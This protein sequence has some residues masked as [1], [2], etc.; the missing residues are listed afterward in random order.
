MH[1]GQSVCARGNSA[2]FRKNDAFD[3]LNKWIDE[4]AQPTI[5]PWP[6]TSGV[7]TSFMCVADA[8]GWSQPE[9][10]PRNFGTFDHWDDDGQL[11]PSDAERP[12][13]CRFAIQLFGHR[14][15]G[16]FLRT[17]RNFGV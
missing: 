13:D 3:L 11:R 7:R 10:D 12:S 8:G 1:F 14:Q 17:G 6:N 5:A 9:S 16:V 15:N 2:R 4:S